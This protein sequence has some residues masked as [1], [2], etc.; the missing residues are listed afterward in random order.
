MA[1]TDTKKRTFTFVYLPAD[2]TEPLEDWQ[3]TYTKEDEVD[4]LFKRLKVCFV[5][6]MHSDK[7]EI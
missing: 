6:N 1:P 4:C 5:T 3:V 7:P 2:V